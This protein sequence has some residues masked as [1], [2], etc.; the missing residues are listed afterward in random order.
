VPVEY[1]QHVYERLRAVGEP[2]GIVNAG[3]R[4]IETLRLEKRYLYWGADISPDYNPYEAGLGFCVALD[5]GDFIGRT[6]LSR[7]KAE[8]PKRRLSGFV[9]DRPAPVYGGE[10]IMRQGRVLGV[11]TSGGYGHTIGKSIVFGYVPAEHAGHADFEIEAFGKA[12]PA[13]RIPRAPYDPDRR[14]I[15]A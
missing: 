10:A 13:Q 4:A 12:V 15:L 6:A 3:Y 7:I 5:K 2:L 1:G 11:T 14:R 9:L 8:G